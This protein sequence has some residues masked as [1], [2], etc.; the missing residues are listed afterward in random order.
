MYFYLVETGLCRAA[1]GEPVL[2]AGMVSVVM[3]VR[4]LGLTCESKA[5]EPSSRLFRFG[6]GAPV[7]RVFSRHGHG[8]ASF[9]SS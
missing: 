8:R 2:R 9:C 4:R 7:R 5:E 6:D 3:A 1:T